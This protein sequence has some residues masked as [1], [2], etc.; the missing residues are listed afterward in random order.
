MRELVAALF[1]NKKETT[2][3]ARKSHAKAQLTNLRFNRRIPISAYSTF[4]R[5]RIP[6]LLARQHEKK[7]QSCFRPPAEVE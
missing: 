2:Q 4:A 1:L 5:P 7:L 6:L 3:L